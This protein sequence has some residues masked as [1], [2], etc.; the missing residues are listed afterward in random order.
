MVV[1]SPTYPTAHLPGTAVPQG[2]IREPRRGPEEA[3]VRLW[4]N[5]DRLASG[6]VTQDGRR[7][8]VLYPGRR[9]SSAGPDFRDCVLST[10]SGD[11]VVGD[12]EVHV[13]AGGWRAHG[14]HV[15]SNYN[16]V[17]LHVVLA[18]SGRSTMTTLESRAE[19]PVAAIGAAQEDENV[20][21]EP[22]RRVDEDT[23]F[24]ALQ[25]KLDRAG[26]ERFRLKADGYAMEL[27]SG[28]AEQVL[29]AGIMEALGYSAN[30]KP[31]AAL[32]ASVPMARLRALRDE[33]GVTRLL[34][35]RAM[36]VSASGLMSSAST[37]D[38]ERFRDILKALPPVEKTAEPWKIFRVRPSN[39]PLRRVEG[40]AV[41]IDRA[42]REGL[43]SALARTV[44]QGTHRP[45]INGL[46]VPPFIG[47]SRAREIAVNVV[48][49]FLYAWG[50]ISRD[51]ELRAASMEIFRRM[52][53]LADNEITR[54]MK[55]L[56]PPG[57]DTRGARRQQGLIHLYKHMR[58]TLL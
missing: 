51:R 12:V 38:A 31:F 41:L 43:V 30:R 55:R 7:L 27:E 19:A 16:G 24:S 32:A 13:N 6:L 40:A 1:Y 46:S 26:D 29:Y 28:D 58:E 3:V 15:D 25:E 17:V 5:A 36:L 2:W 34:A 21:A 8:K 9:S 18:P 42:L 33:P 50:E 57:V 39:H 54:E 52:P 10:D 4:Q 14:H 53:G 44:R 49:P 48:L 47:E 56:L 37:E 22:R 11:I 23:S 45:V 35:I 20:D